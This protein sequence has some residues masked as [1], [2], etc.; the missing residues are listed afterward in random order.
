[1]VA[2]IGYVAFLAGPPLIGFLAEEVG[3]LRALTV[4]RRRRRAR[5][6]G[7]RRAAPAPARR[8][9]TRTRSYAGHGDVRAA[10]LSRRRRRRASRERHPPAALSRRDGAGRAAYDTR[11]PCGA[12]A[13]DAPTRT[14]AFGAHA[15]ISRSR[16][17]PGD[18]R[19]GARPRSRPD[20]R[21]AARPSTLS[22]RQAPRWVQVLAGATLALVAAYTVSV[23][24]G[25]PG[26]P[27]TSALWESWVRSAA[28]ASVAALCLAR[29]LLVTADRC[30]W[31]ALSA[32]LVVLHRRVGRLRHRLR[33]R[34]GGAVRLLR[35]ALWLAS[36]P[37]R[38]SR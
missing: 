4:T 12:V 16:P 26:R 21:A 11:P 19:G 22:L 31:L 8:R 33:R 18:D 36:I 28:Y 6:A 13:V 10:A 34:G 1:M 9:G 3:T 15:T 30:A 25:M 24:P 14:A 37:W 35:G 27:G 17:G 32:A 38:T 7:L 23:L 29:A 5:P 2:T 20:P